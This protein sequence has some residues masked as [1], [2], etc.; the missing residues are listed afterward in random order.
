MTGR[1]KMFALVA[2]LQVGRE[3]E[4]CRQFQQWLSVAVL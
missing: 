4:L 3:R 1:T 2:L